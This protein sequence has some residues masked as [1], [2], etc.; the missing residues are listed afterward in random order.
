MVVPDACQL[1]EWKISQKEW[2]FQ[3]CAACIPEVAC[4]KDNQLVSNRFQ[5]I[6]ERRCSATYDSLG[7][8]KRGTFLL[9]PIPIT[10]CPPIFPAARALR[11]QLD[12]LLFSGL[13]KEFLTFPVNCNS[14]S[15]RQQHKLTFLITIV[16]RVFFPGL[17]AFQVFLE[18]FSV[19]LREKG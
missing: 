16:L 5:T 18:H 9:S 13:R 6:C 14:Q 10:P 3:R 15:E 1:C 17:I 2:T 7:A 11:K 19:R 12:T 4:Y 8:S